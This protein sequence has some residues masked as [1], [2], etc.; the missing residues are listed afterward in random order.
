M[1]RH[2]SQPLTQGAQNVAEQQLTAIYVRVS[3]TTQNADGQRAELER[4]AA[5]QAGPVQWYDDA[6]TGRTMDRPGWRRLEADLRAGRVARIAV[7][8]LDRLGRSV[9]GVAALIDEL[10]QRGVGLVSLRDGIDLSTPAGAMLANILASL[11]QWETEVRADRIRA[12]QAAA[13]AA[14]RTWGGSRAGRVT[15]RTPT[16]AQIRAA[17]DLRA[18][19][20][21]ARAIARATGVNR[22]TVSRLILHNR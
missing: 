10:R 20:H 7:W 8:R 4:W 11:S 22:T 2:D 17:T 5:G 3:T 15:R 18:A 9:S 21:S 12:G 14:G 6:A 13:R 1:I 16:A 19:G